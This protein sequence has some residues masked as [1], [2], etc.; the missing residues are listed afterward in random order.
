[1]T[2]APTQLM[3]EDHN[4]KR[5]ANPLQNL[6]L[7]SLVAPGDIVL[8]PP[9]TAFA[10][11]SGRNGQRSA[12]SSH[13]EDAS[14]KNRNGQR[15]GYRLELQGH[16]REEGNSREGRNGQIS[17][18]RS[19][20]D[21][22][23]MWANARQ[24]RK[25][26]EEE[27]EKPRK[28]NDEWDNNR[29][30]DPRNERRE[31]GIDANGENEDSSRSERRNG[32]SRSHE[33]PLWGRDAK[34]T[35]KVD[36]FSER[37]N[38]RG[39]VARGKRG[40]REQS[41]GWGR[42]AAAD[43]DPLWLGEDETTEEKKPPPTQ[44]DFEEFRAQMKARNS[45][46]A[47][48][49]KADHG[50]QSLPRD[51]GNGTSPSHKKQSETF[52]FSNFHD[53]FYDILSQPKKHHEALA[54]ES[55]Q[56]LMHAAAK[57]AKPSKFTSLFS[58]NPAVKPPIIPAIEDPASED[59]A[60]FQRILKLLDQQQQPIMGEQTPPRAAT[61][62]NSLASPPVQSPPAKPQQDEVRSPPPEHTAKPQDREFLLNLMR[63]PMQNFPEHSRSNINAH[64][65]Q[66]NQ[67]IT[68]PFANLAMSPPQEAPHQQPS[69]GPPPGFF[70]ESFRQEMPPR[71]KLNPTAG[72]Q[73]AAPPGLFDQFNQ[74]QRPPPSTLP[75][76]LERRP[77]G[78][79]HLPSGYGQHSSQRQGMPP[80]P[81]FPPPQR[82]SGS[83]GPGMFPSR[84]NGVGMPPPPGFMNM[85]GPPPPGFM[86][87][88]H[89]GPGLGGGGFELGQG[90]L[91]PG[92]AR[93]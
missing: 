54:E 42:G 80:P 44:E 67:S 69:S 78:F 49:A 93:R 53:T 62:Q 48:P 4:S 16:E 71:D 72:L 5:E 10:S 86:G 56:D 26:D 52:D 39:P 22:P 46:D 82:G 43:E 17:N 83:M 6:G 27:K 87:Y 32:T 18:R 28:R 57:L 70:D 25:P 31:R 88:G 73:R 55:R 59:K 50:S 14:S 64:R 9:K 61:R 74:P 37:S 7:M 8:G 75:P 63:R 19:V 91:P 68:S 2:R 81:G 90:F 23:E 13:D 77:P 36:G 89:E 21:D 30:K 41:H 33:M 51:I 58:A 65:V 38:L 20:K 12:L 24:P 76:G 34:Q 11:A 15:E 85:G 47:A 3:L 35:E 92:H 40:L 60:G 79:D 66:E 1:M 29:T 84:P 45:K